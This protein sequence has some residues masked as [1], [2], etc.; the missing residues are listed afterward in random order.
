LRNVPDVP[1]SIA[2]LVDPILRLLPPECITLTAFKASLNWR[3]SGSSFSQSGLESGH[4]CKLRKPISTFLTSTGLV[5][6][7]PTITW[8]RFFFGLPTP[9][10]FY[11]I[12]FF[13]QSI[14]KVL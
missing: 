1:S 10:T 7:V 8:R 14:S 2:A 4:H 5:S 6:K 13:C 3:R 12:W 11:L 9:S